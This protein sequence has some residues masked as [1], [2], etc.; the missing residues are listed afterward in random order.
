MSVDG[1]VLGAGTVGGIGGGAASVLAETGNPVLVG[2]LVAGAIIV[3]L[4]LLTRKMQTH[5][6]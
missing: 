1:Q 4:G 2:I 3:V 5:E 6:N